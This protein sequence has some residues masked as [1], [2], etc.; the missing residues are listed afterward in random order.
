M[1]EEK[2]EALTPEILE[3]IKPFSGV[4]PIETGMEKMIG[5]GKAIQ[6]VQTQYTTAVAVQQPRSMTRINHNVLEEAKLA[7]AAFYFRWPVKNKKTGKTSMVQGGSIDLAMCIARNYGNCVVDI[8][9]TETPTHFML[10]G[11]FVDLETGFTVPRLFRQRK[12]QNIGGGYGDDRSE[13]MVFQIA[14]SKAQRNAILK[15]MPAWLI[16][17]AIETARDAEIG[18]IKGDNLPLARAKVIEYFSPYGITQERIEAK[19]EIDADHWTAENIAD[20][21]ANATALKEGRVTAEEL[22]PT[23]EKKPDPAQDLKAKLDAG[24]TEI[25]GFSKIKDSVDFLGVGMD[26]VVYEKGKQPTI[27]EGEQEEEPDPS[28]LEQGEPQSILPAGVDPIAWLL[29]SR[30]KS[31]PTN[32]ALVMEVFQAEKKKVESE[33]DAIKARLRRK[34]KDA[35]DYLADIEAK[36]QAIAEEEPLD[37]DQI[38]FSPNTNEGYDANGRLAYLSKMRKYKE[39]DSDKYAKVLMDNSTEEKP[40]NDMN[41]VKPGDEAAILHFMAEEFGE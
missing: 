16:D 2:R 9:G 38:P 18:K 23:I 7:G 15:A 13:D 14:Q 25:E 27:E 31:S 24:D 20:L 41:A 39:K 37:D 22:F 4:S 28:P 12:S 1:T 11:V 21:R 19:I 6:R 30:G 36:K 8:E 26:G 5:E 33:S 29:T 17:K 10:K 40:L 32:A 34:Y 35:M 3:G